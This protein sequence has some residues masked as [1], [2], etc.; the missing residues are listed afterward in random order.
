MKR[1]PPLGPCRLWKGAVNSD[2]YP[3][4]RF[5]GRVELVTRVVLTAKLGR[6]IKPKHEAAHACHRRS[7]I[8]AE[9]LVET[10]HKGNCAM[11]RRKPRRAA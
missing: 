9:H 10:T 2:G 3:V 7:C 5:R 4:M 1:R 11:G 8:E 6:P